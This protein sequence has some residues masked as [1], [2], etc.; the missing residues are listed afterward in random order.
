[1]FQNQERQLVM[2]DALNN[3][4]EIGRVY[5]YSNNSNGITT[6]VIGKA[7]KSTDKGISLEII[8]RKRAYGYADPMLA[9]P[10]CYNSR[11]IINVKANMLFPIMIALKLHDETFK[12]WAKENL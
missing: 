5:G 3:E 4:I 2:Q 1:M 6:I 8:T 7:I 11:A 10:N 9:V 12:D